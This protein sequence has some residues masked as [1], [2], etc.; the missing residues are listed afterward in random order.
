[1]E[2]AFLLDGAVSVTWTKGYSELRWTVSDM[3]EADAE[4]QTPAANTE[5]YD[6]SLY[7]V[8]RAESVPDYRRETVN[9]PVFLSYELTQEVV[10]MRADYSN[11]PGDEGVRLRFGVHYSDNEMLVEISSKGVSPEWI[12]EKLMELGD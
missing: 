4:R 3:T 10:N 11:E 8:P 7:P 5:N 2:S 9:D 1:M 6:L 12:Y